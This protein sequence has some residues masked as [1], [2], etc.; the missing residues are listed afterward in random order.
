MIGPKTCGE[1]EYVIVVKDGKIYIGAG[2]DH[3]DRELE[4]A[5]VPKAKQI[6]A[7]PIAPTLWDYEEL[8]DHWDSITLWTGRKSPT[9]GVLWQI[10]SRWRLF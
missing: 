8:K 2:S 6:C 4:A 10:F 7:K 3:T 1:V 5:S 9:S